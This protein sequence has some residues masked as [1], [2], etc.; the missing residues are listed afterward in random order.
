MALEEDLPEKPEDKTIPKYKQIHKV[1]PLSHSSMIFR[2]KPFLTLF[3]ITS[4][5][6][7]TFSIGA[8][9]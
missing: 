1:S 5:P 8:K 2:S 3:C 9:N 6:A 4:G 7:S